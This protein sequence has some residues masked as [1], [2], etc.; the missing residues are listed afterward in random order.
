MISV[1]LNTGGAS[2][3]DT[4][5][6]VSNTEFCAGAAA[7]VG[8]TNGN[9][10]TGK[11]GGVRLRNVT[12]FAAANL[13]STAAS[14]NS[15]VFPCYVNDCFIFVGVGTALNAGT[16]GQIIE[17]YNIIHA[18]TP[19]TNVSIGAHSISDGSYAPL[20][21][22]GQE[23]IWGA[24]LRPFGE[25]MAGSPLLG[26]GNDGAQTA[27]DLYNRP[28][29]AGGG[30]LPVPAAGALERGNTPAQ[31]T[32]P[33]PPSGTHDWQFTGPGYQDFL[34]PVSNA[35]T[36]IAI[37]VQRDTAYSAPPG[38]TLPA[39]LILANGTLGVAAQTVV[40]TGAASQWNTLTSA[41]FT[42]SGY[43]WVT[44]RIA[45]YDGSGTSLVSFASVTVT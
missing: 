35:A 14:Q 22:F 32:S 19:R 31:A 9:T 40:D 45:S 10:S 20:V 26:F 16:S 18:S 2:D 23:R 4:N 36:T 21:H 34:L 28:R 7:A 41:A 37:S 6:V 38:A 13:M 24:L 44:V 39:M 3:Y 30:A 27:Y 12:R 29:P 1:T 8:V 5:F 33:A 11:G 25:P 17:D 43:G 42:P 15:T